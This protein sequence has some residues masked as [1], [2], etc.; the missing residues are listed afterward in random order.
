MLNRVR[1]IRRYQVRRRRKRRIPPSRTQDTPHPPR[2]AK[3]RPGEKAQK[4]R[5]RVAPGEHG[6][7]RPAAA[8]LPSVVGHPSIP[9]QPRTTMRP[10]GRAASGRPA[11]KSAK[12][13]CNRPRRPTRLKKEVHPGKTADRYWHPPAAPTR[14][15][16]AER[17][18]E[19]DFSNRQ[20]AVRAQATRLK[21]RIS[22]ALRYTCD[23]GVSGQTG[24]DAPH[25]PRFETARSAGFIP[26]AEHARKSGI[27]RIS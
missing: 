27:H 9:S 1:R 25:L 23:L 6:P 21:N 19:L 17:N 2:Q 3:R 10:C 8:R 26:N 20:P 4:P 11:G 15:I 13:A 7:R 24:R 12:R 18:R 16:Y 22:H 5:I 14:E